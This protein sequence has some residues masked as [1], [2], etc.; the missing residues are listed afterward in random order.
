MEIRTAEPRPLLNT[1][2]DVSTHYIPKAPQAHW[3][4]RD[5]T[6]LRVDKNYILSSSLLLFI[7]CAIILT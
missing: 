6:Q 4:W 2:G 1:K 3:P 7:T 5:L